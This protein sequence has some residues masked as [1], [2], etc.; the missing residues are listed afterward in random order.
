MTCG[1]GTATR[2]KQDD[3][4]YWNTGDCRLGLLS[5]STHARRS[6]AQELTRL[7]TPTC[8][9]RGRGR[10]AILNTMPHPSVQHRLAA[11]HDAWGD[12]SSHA[13]PLYQH[14]GY[15]HCGHVHSYVIQT[16]PL[17]ATCSLCNRR[18]DILCHVAY[19]GF[20]RCS[21][22]YLAEQA[23]HAAGPYAKAISGATRFNPC[24]LKKSYYVQG[25]EQSP[26][27]RTTLLEAPM[28]LHCIR[29]MEGYHMPSIV[30]LSLYCTFITPST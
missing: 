17:Q 21:P 14:S 8:P 30:Q 28:S 9:L 7:D 23:Y 20:V 11:S 6:A 12:M 29:S 27:L 26:G 24:S 10:A 1:N 13:S 3:W 2:Q 15:T 25:N 5:D 18:E 22:P 4:V 16:G 19:F